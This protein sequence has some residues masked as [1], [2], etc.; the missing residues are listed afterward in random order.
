ML[1]AAGLIVTAE[2]ETLWLKPSRLVT[3]GLVDVARQHK[4]TLLKALAPIPGQWES[5][6]ADLIPP[7]ICLD[8][9]GPAPRDGMHWCAACRAKE[10]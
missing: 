9:G 8:C 7:A 3:P 10:R 1:R 5:A 2:G 4:R 6:H